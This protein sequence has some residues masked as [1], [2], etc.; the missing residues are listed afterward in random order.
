MCT[1][2]QPWR[3]WDLKGALVGLAWHPAGSKSSAHCLPGRGCRVGLMELPDSGPWRGP[4]L[5][6]T[7]TAH[8]AGRQAVR[9]CALLPRLR[10]LFV[11]NFAL[12]VDL[13]LLLAGCEAADLAG[14]QLCLHSPEVHQS[15]GLH[16]PLT[17]LERGTL[18]RCQRLQPQ[19]RVNSCLC[20]YGTQRASSEVGPS[21][22][23]GLSEAPPQRLWRR[24]RARWPCAWN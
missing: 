15:P 8:D 17:S 5:Q 9:V 3:P 20:A 1:L 21:L 10:R 19:R 23:L 24:Q 22:S 2:W 6:G 7:A 16:M 18:R 14:A 11:F 13:G 4:P 12:V